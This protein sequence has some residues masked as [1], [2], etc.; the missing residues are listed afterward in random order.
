MISYFP[1]ILEAWIPNST[2]KLPK[3]FLP[4]TSGL[5]C[6]VGLV[7]LASIYEAEQ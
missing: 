6:E 4:Q 2:K 5:F 7:V 1:L 3:L